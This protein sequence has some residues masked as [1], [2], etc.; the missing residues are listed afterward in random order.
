MGKD[1][2]QE[3]IYYV[4]TIDPLEITG[5]ITGLLA[6]IWLIRQNILTWPAGIIYVLASVIIFWKEKL[7]AD[8]ALHI[9]YLFLNGYG[10]YYWSA[11]KKGTKQ[12]VPVTTTPIGRHPVFDNDLDCRSADTGPYIAPLYGC[13]TALLGQR[14]HYIELYRDVANR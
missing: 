14:H 6:V 1:I 13:F 3:I 9:F 8:L 10:W 12:E 4:S 11:G 5:L 2:I 7:Y